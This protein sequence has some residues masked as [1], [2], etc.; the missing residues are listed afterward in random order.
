MPALMET[1]RQ[2]VLRP[3]EPLRVLVEAGNAAEWLVLYV[4]DEGELDL[5]LE[6]RDDGRRN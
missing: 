5:R 3:G 1:E 6:R 2:A 4:D